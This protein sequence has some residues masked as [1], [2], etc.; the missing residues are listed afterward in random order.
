MTYEYA[1]TSVSAHVLGG[2]SDLEP[3]KP[4]DGEGWELV[5]ASA[6]ESTR[7]HDWRRPVKAKK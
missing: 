3:P 4:P 5:S 1:T 6:N 7:F 2:R